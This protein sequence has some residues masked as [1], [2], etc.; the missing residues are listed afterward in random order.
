[1]RFK[2]PIVLMR[3]KNFR[4]DVAWVAIALFV[5]AEM[6]AI[7]AESDKFG[8]A[9]AVFAVFAFITAMTSI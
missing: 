9:G 1:M 7:F 3:D 6:I 5:V 4:R 8:W 2:N